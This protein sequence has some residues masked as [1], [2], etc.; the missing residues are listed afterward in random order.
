MDAFK[1]DSLDI[2]DAYTLVE[3]K[4]FETAATEFTFDTVLDGDADES[5]IIRHEVYNDSANTAFYCLQINGSVFSDGWS[6]LRW[7]AGIDGDQRTYAQTGSGVDKRIGACQSGGYGEGE[8]LMID[9]TTSALK[10][11]MYN[12]FTYTDE[13]GGGND[14]DGNEVWQYIITPG[15]GTNITSLGVGAYTT[16]TAT[17]PLTNGIGVGSRFRLY[18][19]G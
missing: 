16:G 10:R 7:I 17:T 5:Y 4:S 19:L 15:E 11:A 2:T 6:S 18:K 14:I 3:E 1:I 9:A 12:S 8:M 13:L